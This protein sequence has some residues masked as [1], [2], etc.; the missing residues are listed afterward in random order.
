[1][2]GGLDAIMKLPV[3]VSDYKIFWF[4]S[5]RYQDCSFFELY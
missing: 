1:M 4:F 5:R 2:G 3:C